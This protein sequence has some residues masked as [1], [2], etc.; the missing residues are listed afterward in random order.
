M[1]KAKLYK[2]E[3]KKEENSLLQFIIGIIVYALVLMIAN[4]LFKG[5]YIINFKYAI[6]AAL[7]LSFLNATIKP[8]LI[9]FTLPLSIITFGVAYPIVNM[10]ILKICDI[11]MGNSFQIN[12]LFNTFFIAIFISILKIFLDRIITKKVG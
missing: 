9:Y 3:S 8:L 1:S 5:I 11:L 7:I 6:I 4:N 12:G 2:I 10:F